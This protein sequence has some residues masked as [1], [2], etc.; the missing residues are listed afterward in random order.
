[1]RY[2]TQYTVGADTS[3]AG[4]SMR[5]LVMQARTTGQGIVTG[6]A[7]AN[8]GISKL[9]V[10]LGAAGVAMTALTVLPS[11]LRDVVAEASEIGKVADRIGIGTEALQELRFSAEKFG[12]SA[13][14][15][16]KALQEF[17]KRIGEALTGTGN[18]KKILDANGISLRD[19]NGN[20]KDTLTLMSE[21]ADLIGNAASQ[22]EKA[23]LAQ[24]AFSRSGQ[25]MIN[26]LQNGSGA[27][28]D[29]IENARGLGVAINDDLIR[30]AE[31]WDDLWA[32][33]TRSLSTNFKTT[34][35]DIVDSLALISNEISGFVD[36]PSLRSFLQVFDS[37]ANR[38]LLGLM[39]GGRAL[40]RLLPASTADA[41]TSQT[42]SEAIGNRISGAFDGAEKSISAADSALV[43]LLRRKG[44]EYHGLATILPGGSSEVVNTLKEEIEAMQRSALEQKIIVAL[45][46][47]NT[48]AIT[49]EGQA[50][51]ALVTKK[52]T[53]E[54]A[55]KSR[56]SALT[57]AK[58][59]A[60]EAAQASA[61]AAKAA[62]QERDRING[63]IEALR[64]EGAEIGQT[65]Q[66]RNTATALRRAGV[67][68][69]SDEGRAIAELV[70]RNHE[71]EQAQINVNRQRESMIEANRFVADSTF[72]MFDS[73][74]TGA[75]SAEDA[76]KNL[77]TQLLRAV[78][79]AALLGQGPLA[80]VFGTAQSGG[81]LNMGL[82]AGSAPLF[83]GSMSSGTG[84]TS[85]VMAA[86]AA[87]T[88]GLFAKGGISDRPAIFGEAGPEA[89]VPLTGSRKIPVDLRWTTMPSQGTKQSAPMAPQAVHVTVGVD[90]NGNL[91]AY[92]D[93]VARGRAVQ[94]VQT[95][96]PI[97]AD[98]AE[99]Q[100]LG[101]LRRGTADKTL[102]GRYGAPAKA[103]PR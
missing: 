101:G 48:T 86:I 41:V 77:I 30:K 15:T 70:A 71:L 33:F 100:T 63:V 38:N 23:F 98:Q 76:V 85:A 49:K 37:S 78:A 75:T 1:M 4:R 62:E 47:A 103:I 52:H 90:D 26:V 73:F 60:S 69:A 72:Q 57:A 94:A 6:L 21:Y 97:I 31:V 28:K 8:A 79:Q 9:T 24:E 16:D 54:E 93:R 2:D 61:A 27:F 45:R 88:G 44:L 29:Q 17:N 55:E 89:A 39:P 40:N 53:L 66:Q 7:P 80:G 14:E 19:Q 3:A 11:I 64:I 50:I 20:M 74:V 32:D 81:L 67:D 99:A 82:N 12:V 95:A 18:L 10:G 36:S 34:A 102:S 84:T 83:T 42:E 43:M 68:A 65:A 22:Q 5:G 58:Q 96:G 87:G 46:K 25:K 51:V 35:L 13:G 56:A 91:Q 92:V 59:A